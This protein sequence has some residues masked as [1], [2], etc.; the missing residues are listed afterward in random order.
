M[1]TTALGFK[2]C[3]ECEMNHCT[4]LPAS[5]PSHVWKIFDVRKRIDESVFKI[6][7]MPLSLQ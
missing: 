1:P 6:L 4:F 3:K 5:C 7:F 2:F